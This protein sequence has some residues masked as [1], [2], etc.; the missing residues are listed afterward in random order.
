MPNHIYKLRARSR[1][2]SFIAG[3]LLVLLFLMPVNRNALYSTTDCTDCSRTAFLERA[4]SNLPYYIDH[5]QILYASTL[6]R[7]VESL[8]TPCFHLI[9][10]AVIEDLARQGWPE[11]GRA[12]SQFRVP[13]YFFLADFSRIGPASGKAA[14]AGGTRL[15][16]ELVYNGEPNETVFKLASESPLEDYSSHVNRMYQNRDAVINQVK[17]I[18]GILRDFERRPV[19]CEIDLGE[20]EEVTPGEEIEVKL[21]DFRDEQGRASKYFNRVV[22]EA[23]HGRIKGGSRVVAGE[24]MRAFRVE[25]G[26]I[27]FTYRAPDDCAASEDRI[28]VHSS[29]TILDPGK[30]PMEMTSVDK[31]ISEKAVRISCPDL[32]ADYDTTLKTNLE[33][34]SGTFLSTV[35]ASYRLTSSVKTNGMIWEHYKCLS[36]TLIN[37]QGQA[38]YSRQWKSADCEGSCYGTASPSGPK[39]HQ[40]GVGFSLFYDEKTGSV[41]KVWLDSIS[42]EV[43]C[44]IQVQCTEKCKHP[45]SV[46]S[47][48]LSIPLYSERR[49][50]VGVVDDL[51][52]VERV[53]G[54]REGGVIS[55]SA[56]FN[57]SCWDHTLRFSFRKIKR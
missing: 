24:T 10:K 36:S 55:G 18:D 14:E 56:K 9:N 3:T 7:L 13:E 4:T 37:F 19:S 50:A 27:T 28:I 11:S 46:R 44:I 31:K 25:G 30:E 47:Y 20:T 32:V 39:I 57:L 2:S 22:V 49:G 21:T 42:I 26:T 34:L 5:G 43:E 35:K 29:C 33:A 48:Q 53:S 51:F 12:L 38:V 40:G 6:S 17:P 41:Q 16:L 1:E 23:R 52:K 45:P 15:S 54:S 8:T